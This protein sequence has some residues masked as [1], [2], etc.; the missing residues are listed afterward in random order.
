MAEVSHDIIGYV[1][2]YYRMVIEDDLRELL[3]RVRAGDYQA[4]GELCA[5]YEPEIRRFIRARLVDARLYRI[6]DSA[7]IFQ[8]VFANFYVKLMAGLYDLN[9]PKE[10]FRLLMVMV[11][12]KVIDAGRNAENRRTQN[13]DTGFWY[14]ATDAVNRPSEIVAR[15]E[16]LAAAR[17]LLTDE[18]QELVDL[19][20]EGLSWLEIG[21]RYGEAAGTVRRRLERALERVCRQLGLDEA[22]HE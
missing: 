6:L 15:A 1:P 4:A 22:P 3:R 12:N 18:E 10:L 2:G 5:H 14:T 21:E 8:S 7:D 20:A 11:K 19:R 13:G 9:D 16:L 17:E